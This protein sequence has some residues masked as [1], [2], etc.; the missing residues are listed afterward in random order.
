MLCKYK[1]L[2]GKPNQGF[3]K[4]IL[5]IALFDV[6][7]TLVISFIIY[8]LPL[9]SEKPTKKF[10]FIIFISVF[11]LGIILHRI[12]CVNTTVNKLIFGEI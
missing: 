7:G 6:I 11:L 3:H 12:F 4:H 10:F 1:D 8:K 2:L 9:W 5:G